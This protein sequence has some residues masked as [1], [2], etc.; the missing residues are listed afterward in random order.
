MIRADLKTIYVF[1]RRAAGCETSRLF[2]NGYRPYF[3]ILLRQGYAET[4]FEGQVL[5]IGGGIIGCSRVIVIDDLLLSAGSRLV[6][7]DDNIVVGMSKLLIIMGAIAVY[8]LK[9]GFFSWLLGD[10]GD[11]IKSFFSGIL[12]IY[13]Y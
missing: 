1:Q 6:G 2:F 4:G 11:V 10:L 7:R 12:A 9:S 13:I 3:A 8:G 5:I